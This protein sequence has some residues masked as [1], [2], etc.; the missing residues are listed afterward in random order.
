MEMFLW[1]LLCFKIIVTEGGNLNVS[2][3]SGLCGCCWA[4][5]PRYKRLVDNIFPEDPEVNTCTSTPHSLHIYFSVSVSNVIKIQK[6][7]LY[8]TYSWGFNKL[9]SNN[10]SVCMCVCVRSGRA[11]ESQHG[12][13]DLLRS[14]CSGEAR[15]HR[16]VPV[17]ASDQRAEPPPLRV[18]THKHTKAHTDGLKIIMLNGS[19]HEKN[20]T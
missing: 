18:S 1:S 20:S 16:C 13:V 15:P 6:C 9:H 2:L 14:V 7:H 17:R 5:R 3:C 11:G 10:L 12:E 8:L 19:L 4:L